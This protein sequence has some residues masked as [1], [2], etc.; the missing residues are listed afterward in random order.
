MIE[1]IF[2]CF[3]LRKSNPIAIL[4]ICIS[5][6]AQ[7]AAT[8]S[9]N[10]KYELLKQIGVMK[11][12]FKIFNSSMKIV[13]YFARLCSFKVL[14]GWGIGIFGMFCSQFAAYLDRIHS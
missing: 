11:L 5:K 4:I 13:S 1:A 10:I 6:P 8:G 7:G 12:Q 9:K 2:D 14:I 3:P